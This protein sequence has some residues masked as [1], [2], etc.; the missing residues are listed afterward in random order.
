M[1][2]SIGVIGMALMSVGLVLGKPPNVSFKMGGP[3][4]TAQLLLDHVLF[5]GEQ[6]YLQL[7]L[8]ISASTPKAR[9]EISTSLVRASLSLGWEDA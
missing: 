3:I 1:R 5:R 9:T 7:A 4:S 6:S 8:I 2:K